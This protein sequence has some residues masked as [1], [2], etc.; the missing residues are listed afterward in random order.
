MFCCTLLYVHSSIAIILMGKRELIA[1]INL[2]SWCLV[3]VECLFLAVPQG[4]L[5]LV[6]VVFPDHTHLLFLKRVKNM[7]LL[8]TG[9]LAL[10]SIL[11][12]CQHGFRSQR[13]CKTQLVQFVHDIISNLDGAVNRGHKQTD[14][15]IM[16]FAKAFDKVPHRRPLHKLEYYGIR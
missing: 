13:S 5:Q 14:L 3:M 12:D 6:I 10:D 9:H 8:T 16:D 7:M 2:S 11:A 4:C 15:I 1:L